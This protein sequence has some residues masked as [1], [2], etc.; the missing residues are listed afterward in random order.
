VEKVDNVRGVP[1]TREK[2]GQDH[3]EQREKLPSGQ[4]KSG[5]GLE[6]GL[7][8]TDSGS[9][10]LSISEGGGEF[11]RMNKSKGEGMSGKENQ[12]DRKSGGGE[13]KIIAK[14]E[15]DI[16]D[17]CLR[18]RQTVSVVRE[19]GEGVPKTGKTTTEKDSWGKRRAKWGFGQGC[20]V[21]WGLGGGVWWWGHVGVGCWVGGVGGWCVQFWGISGVVGGGGGRV[22]GLVEWGGF[23][24]GGG[25]GGWVDDFVGRGVCRGGGFCGRAGVGGCVWGG[26]LGVGL[27]R[28]GGVGGVVFGGCGLFRPAPRRR[29]PSGTRPSLLG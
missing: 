29:L 2:R 14:E 7:A 24:G 26:A 9:P 13:N 18:S 20:G 11:R 15:F 28:W 5:S 25:R 22:F 23:G 19:R 1:C 21:W 8:R 10:E 27:R 12:R 4:R 3:P 17:Q 6:M 16:C